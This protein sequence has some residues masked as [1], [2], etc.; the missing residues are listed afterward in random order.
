MTEAEAQAS[1]I[2]NRLTR[3]LGG[4]ADVHVD[5]LSPIPLKA[6][7]KIL[8]C[9][10]DLTRYALRED[11]DKLTA[12]GPP[13]EIVERA[14]RYAN[15]RGGADNVSAILVAYGDVAALE[16]TIR[17]QQPQ[18]PLSIEETL[19][20]IYEKST[21]KSIKSA[22]RF[23]SPAI[24]FEVT[25]TITIRAA[26]SIMSLSQKTSKNI[27]TRIEKISKPK[28]GSYVISLGYLMRSWY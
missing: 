11:I 21:R 7:D 23:V 3:S 13:R 28:E 14:I 20:S 25:K 19:D 17:I 26:R 18:Q 15:H 2:K 5:V 6:G 9:S 12:N 4:E 1:K 16:P 10:D 27:R 24:I 22:G 8:L